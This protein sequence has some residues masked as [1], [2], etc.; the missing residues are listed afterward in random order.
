MTLFR[1]QVP[2]LG[3]ENAKNAPRIF[4]TLYFSSRAEVHN[5]L[6][7]QINSA[8]K[9]NAPDLTPATN[10]TGRRKRRREKQKHCS[11]EGQGKEQG[12]ALY[13][14]DVEFTK[15]LTQDGSR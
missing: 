6:A 2:K 10:A 12:A 4:H 14:T 3:L 7:T 15:N 8:S 1:F 13:C 11:F 9:N 5:F